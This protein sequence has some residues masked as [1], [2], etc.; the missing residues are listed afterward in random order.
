MTTK[1]T[2]KPS[3]VEWKTENKNKLIEDF[4]KKYGNKM[5]EYSDFCEYRYAKAMKKLDR[6]QLEPDR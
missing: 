3:F 4:H 6:D 5:D 2:N 1:I